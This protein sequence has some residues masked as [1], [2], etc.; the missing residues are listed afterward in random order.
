ME[1]Q[2]DKGIHAAIEAGIIK[3]GDVVVITAGL[4]LQTTGTTNMLRV[5]TIT[6]EGNIS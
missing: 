3:P 5:H 6:E 2:I 4:P 1:A